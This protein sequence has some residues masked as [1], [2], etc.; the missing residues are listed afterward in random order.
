M[1]LDLSKLKA[2]RFS[3]G[4][5]RTHKNLSRMGT[6]LVLP[7]QQISF[8]K[9]VIKYKATNYQSNFTQVDLAIAQ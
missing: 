2:K 6:T 3:Q 4:R 5:S 7:K 1:K 8:H 9:I